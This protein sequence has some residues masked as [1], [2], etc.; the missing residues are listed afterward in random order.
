MSAD[1]ELRFLAL[2]ANEV[3]ALEVL[4]GK[5]NVELG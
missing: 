3:P 4:Q 2:V 1:G 5:S